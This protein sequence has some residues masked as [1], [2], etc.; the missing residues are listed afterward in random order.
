[1]NNSF[2]SMQ[3]YSAMLLPMCIIYNLFSISIEIQINKA[4]ISA[5]VVIGVL[6]PMQTIQT[7]HGE[8]ISTMAIRTTIISQMII[9]FVVFEPESQNRYV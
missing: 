2:N 5:R 3:L 8:S 4:F 6:L 7:M 9:M 1:M